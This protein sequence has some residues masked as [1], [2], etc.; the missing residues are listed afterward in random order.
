MSPTNLQL[1][2]K[3][4]K[5]QIRRCKV[6]ALFGSPQKRGIIYKVTTMSP[7]KPN[8]AKRP[9]VK[10]RILGR[11]TFG[12]KAFA[13]IPGDGFGLS[14]LSIFHFVLLEG[15]GPKDSPGLNYT[16]IRGALDFINLEQ[17][18]R[19]NRRSKYGAKKLD[20]EPVKKK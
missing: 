20:Y 1:A 18:G 15:G 6:L 3:G 10:V 14:G 11:G 12:K 16:L 4:R 19:K 7:R 5:K 17:F 8:S 9:F 13:H 2:R